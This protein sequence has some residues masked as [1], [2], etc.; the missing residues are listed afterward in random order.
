MHGHISANWW[1]QSGWF[2][3]AFSEGVR[4][5]LHFSV[6]FEN[7]FIVRDIYRG[8]LSLNSPQKVDPQSWALQ[9]MIVGHSIVGSRNDYRYTVNL[10]TNPFFCQISILIVSFLFTMLSKSMTPTQRIWMLSIV[11]NCWWPFTLHHWWIVSVV[12]N[13]FG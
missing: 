2:A 10:L 8:R 4:L 3:A 6:N 7:L 11:L 13:H 12:C 9:N 5:T 1:T